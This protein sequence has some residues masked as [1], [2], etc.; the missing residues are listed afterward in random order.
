MLSTRYLSADP[1]PPGTVPRVGGGGHTPEGRG[2]GKWSELRGGGA[3][4]DADA[5]LRTHGA[6]GGTLRLRGHL[7][8]ALS[9]PPAA[10]AALPANPPLPVPSGSSPLTYLFAVNDPVS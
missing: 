3:G 6:G 9:A 5:W 7:V 1:A 10:T 2:P 4:G 8:D